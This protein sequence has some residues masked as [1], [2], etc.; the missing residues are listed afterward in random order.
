MPIV[1]ISVFHETKE[2]NEITFYGN[3]I[4]NEH[5]GLFW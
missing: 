2:P 4:L 1:I 5:T 3:N